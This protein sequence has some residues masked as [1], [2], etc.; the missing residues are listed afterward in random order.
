M[1]HGLK[2]GELRP[3]LWAD[4]GCKRQGQ[5]VWGQYY[6]LFGWVNTVQRSIQ[7]GRQLTGLASN[8]FSI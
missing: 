6:E 7:G 2:L 8:E 5:G 1:R 4:C 3:S